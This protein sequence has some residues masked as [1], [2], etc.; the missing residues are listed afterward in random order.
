MLDLFKLSTE[1]SGFGADFPYPFC[2]IRYY[3]VY[4]VMEVFELPG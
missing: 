4:N 3:W 1:L 2:V